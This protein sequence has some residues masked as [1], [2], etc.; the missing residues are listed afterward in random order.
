MLNFV[1]NVDESVQLLRYRSSLDPTIDPSAHTC[2]RLQMTIL[3]E[4]NSEMVKN[5]MVLTGPPPNAEVWEQQ[6]PEELRHLA[7]GWVDF[8]A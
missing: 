4:T 3:E 8:D 5:V 6:L 1:G 7:R 2:M